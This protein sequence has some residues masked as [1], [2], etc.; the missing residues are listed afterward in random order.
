MPN[1]LRQ[2]RGGAEMVA[3]EGAPE[4][5]S[6]LRPAESVETTPNR[7]QIVQSA[8]TTPSLM[9]VNEARSK[10]YMHFF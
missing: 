1:E 3:S 9:D 6:L 7:W 10:M 2:R 4:D 8:Y 5:A